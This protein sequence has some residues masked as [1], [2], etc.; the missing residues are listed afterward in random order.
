MEYELVTYCGHLAIERHELGDRE[1]ETS[2][3]DDKLLQTNSPDHFN[4]LQQ[5]SFRNL[6]KIKET[7]VSCYIEKQ[8]QN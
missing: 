5:K 2:L 7:V 3:P 4:S 6:V 1:R 8:M